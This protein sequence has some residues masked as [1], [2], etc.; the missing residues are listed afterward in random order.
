MMVGRRM[1][2]RRD[3]RERIKGATIR[4]RDLLICIAKGRIRLSIVHGGEVNIE[5]GI[6]RG[7]NHQRFSIESEYHRLK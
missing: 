7:H 4:Q 2:G 5:F 1:V 3:E 6:G